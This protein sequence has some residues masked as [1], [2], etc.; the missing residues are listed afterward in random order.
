[1]GVSSAA[2]VRVYLSCTDERTGLGKLGSEIFGTGVLKTTSVW[3]DIWVRG[4]AVVCVGGSA[5]KVKAVV[6]D[7]G[8]VKVRSSTWCLSRGGVAWG[9]AGS[10]REVLL[11][12]LALRLVLHG[13][14]VGGVGGTWAGGLVLGLSHHLLCLCSVVACGALGELSSTVGVLGSKVADLTGLFVDQVAGVIQ[15]A[16]NGLA[17]LDVD[18]RDSVDDSGGNQ[19]NAPLG[20]K[21][22][23]EVANQGRGEGLPIT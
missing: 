17:V 11:G 19:S 1:M 4:D 21:L 18:Q 5:G 7:A 12:K 10:G 8:W 3:D 15:S 16:V 22:D 14:Q 13:V 2:L 9:G 20:N 23:K 6:V